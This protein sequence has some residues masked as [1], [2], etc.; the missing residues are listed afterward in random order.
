M[1]NWPLRDVALHLLTYPLEIVAGTLPWSLLLLCYLRRDFRESIRTAR[2]QVLFLTICL[3]VAFPTCWIHPG[4]QPRFF[5]PLFPCM[6]VLIGLAV[7]TCVGAEPSS[8]LHLAW[9]RYTTVLAYLMVGVAAAVLVAAAF[10]RNH[11]TL[12]PWA[13]PPFVALAFAAVA[14]GLAALILRASPRTDRS[15]AR[16]AV[17]CLACFLLM[18]FT[19]LV[20]DVR[21]RRSEDA[22]SAMKQVKEH[23]PPAQHLVSFGYLDCLFSYHYGLPIIT[24]TAWPVAGP[25]PGAGLTYFCFQCPGNSRPTLPFLWEEIGAVSLDRN[26]HPVPEQVVVVGRRLEGVRD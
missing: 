7:Q 25:N 15:R 12:A 24:P 6:A 4:G 22:A 11:R 5:A 14:V 2:P 1:Q 17:L 8:R 10:L 19:G 16:T 13:E 18:I 3:A 20:T 21:L 9:R 23:L 26:H